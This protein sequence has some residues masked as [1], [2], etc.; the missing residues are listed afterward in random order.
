MKKLFFLTLIITLSIQFNQAQSIEGSWKG[1]L[2]VMGQ[3]I[4]LI[5][6]FSEKEGEWS[7]KMD[8]P[9]QGAMGI[10]MRK[11]LFDGT[12]ISFEMSM[13]NAS[14]EGLLLGEQIKGNFSQSGMSIPLDF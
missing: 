14:Y 12:M 4:P 13:G 8:S 11:V 2:A 3:K 10:A 5:V 1:E 9:N 6:H 7:G